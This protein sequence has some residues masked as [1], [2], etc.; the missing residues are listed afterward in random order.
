MRLSDNVT[1]EMLAGVIELALQDMDK[2]RREAREAWEADKADDFQRCVSD[3]FGLAAD[4]VRARLSTLCEDDDG[5][6]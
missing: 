4:M 1:R 2:A 3:V 6:S 5:E